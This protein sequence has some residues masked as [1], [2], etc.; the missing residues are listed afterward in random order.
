[1]NYCPAGSCLVNRLSDTLLAQAVPDAQITTG[2][3]LAASLAL[4]IF[5]S[6]LTMLVR[7]G[8]RY[9][10]QGNTLPLARRPF[11]TVPPTVTWFTAMLSLVWVA[12]Q[13][14]V[15]FSPAE[16]PADVATETGI[17]GETPPVDSQS[18]SAPVSTK[19]QDEQLRDARGNI[20][21][22]L[23]MNAI[24][25]TGLGISVLIATLRSRSRIQTHTSSLNNNEQT[26]DP[27]SASETDRYS[28][29]TDLPLSSSP[30]DASVI[31]DRS[32]VNSPSTEFPV[33]LDSS[34]SATDP[35]PEPFSFRA[36]LV[37]AIEVFLVAWFPTMFLRFL[38]VELISQVTGEVPES[39]PLL[40][41]LRSGPGQELML[42]IALTAVV[43]APIAEELQFRVVLLGG[44]LQA[45][46]PQ[47][48]WL[49]SSALFAMAHGFPDSL[50]LLPLSFLLGYA[51]MRRR[52][53]VAVML[54]HFLFNLSNIALAMLSLP[55]PPIS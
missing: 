32:L 53:Y 27:T 11:L 23:Q 40:E 29:L 35:D 12:A 42:L 44:L 54:V 33:S 25:T 50:A 24:L 4:F 5:V 14:A 8:Q 46:R 7:W 45:G 9:F 17:E 26:A 38:L 20:F 22:I 10:R 37:Y 13:L 43:V 2:Q 52:S 6:S 15:S 49:F 3:A 55:Q 47:V 21:A 16:K 31:P 36:E 51:Y 1:M 39:N 30:S 28:S 41:L 19:N 34:G 18:E 48:A